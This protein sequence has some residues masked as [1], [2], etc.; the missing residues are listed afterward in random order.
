[1]SVGALG[2]GL[3]V[4]FLP[5][6]VR[7]SVFGWLFFGGCGRL[8]WLGICVVLMGYVD[9]RVVVGHVFVC[10]FLFLVLGFLLLVA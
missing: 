1:M 9:F 7:G 8:F 2:F 3:V 4:P 10:R 6:V 5:L